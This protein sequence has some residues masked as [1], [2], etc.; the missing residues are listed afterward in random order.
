MQPSERAELKRWLQMRAAQLGRWRGPASSEGMS[1]F[2][3]DGTRGVFVSDGSRGTAPRYGLFCS[4]DVGFE[5][6]RMSREGCS[7]CASSGLGDAASDLRSLPLPG[8]LERYVV[9][10]APMS[11]LRRDLGAATAQI[12]RWVYSAGAVLAILLAAKAYK[13]WRDEPARSEARREAR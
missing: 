6:A 5:Q 8:A 4:G 1:P 3:P 9:T 2:C 12:P 11:S 10:G 13:T 7:S